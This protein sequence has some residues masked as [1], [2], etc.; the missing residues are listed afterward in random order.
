SLGG[1]DL[2]RRA[3]G[4]KK[5]DVMAQQRVVFAD[6]AKG[7]GI[8]PKIATKVFD[9]MES[10]AAY[11]FNKSHSAAYALLTYY[12]AWLKVH[13][14]VEFWA[15][16]LTNDRDNAD[17]VAKGIRHAR[18]AGVDVL[19]PDVNRSVADFDVVDGKILFGMAG[20]KGVG[21]TAVEAI[22]EA[23]QEGGAFESFFDFCERVDLRRVNKK[24][25]EAL[26]RT[27]A[28]DAFGHPRARLVAGIDVAFERAQN[29]QRDK[30]SGQ[31]SLFGMFDAAAGKDTGD[32]DFPPEVLEVG[33]WPEQVLLAHEKSVLGFYVSG[34]PLDR[35][36]DQ[37]NRYANATVESLPE[38]ENYD[39]VTLA[40]IVQ[41][42]RIRPLKRGDGRMAILQFEDLTG[43][44]EAICMSPDLDPVEHLLTSDEPILITGSVRI[45]RDEDGNT[46]ITLRVGQQRRRGEVIDGDEVVVQSLAE[47]RRLRSK[48]VEVDLTAGQL[49]PPA[50]DRLARILQAEKHQGHC[51]TWLNV[52]TADNVLVRLQVPSAQVEPSDALTHE[53]RQVLGDIE[54]HTR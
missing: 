32:D 30:A 5:F 45:D 19:P 49:T 47:V 7:R 54:V 22:V 33:E 26:A 9:L 43:G 37:I 35:F 31:A 10:F 39:R 2:L 51:A 24:T 8:D 36:A 50:V 18:H 16:V 13:H 46:R 34:H 40:G 42:A 52:T 48:R 1:A 14:P 23:R 17:K 6:G 25:I 12:T 53:L 11:G 29:A 3:M 15:S 38:R 28:F 20:V 27:G 41:S 21:S 44:I 4:K